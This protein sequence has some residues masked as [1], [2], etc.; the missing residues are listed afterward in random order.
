[1][2]QEKLS[3]KWDHP[4]P[5]TRE[6]VV[7]PEQI[8]GLGHTNNCEYLKWCEQMAWAHSEAL[9]LGLQE[10]RELGFGMAAVRTELDYLAATYEGEQLVIGTWL[11]GSDGKIDLTRYYQIVRP[12]DGAV[13]LR[14]Q[15]RFVC[16]SM[17]TGRLRRMP[18][19]FVEAYTGA[20]ITLPTT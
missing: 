5:F 3:I 9:G 7:A 6:F 1:M 19:E 13:V 11:I 4:D 8:D 14:G 12:V 2:S 18:P 15:T 16:V 20:L 17:E 10:Y